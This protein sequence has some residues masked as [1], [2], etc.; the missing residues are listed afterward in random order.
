MPTPTLSLSTPPS[1][2]SL[3]TPPKD[4]RSEFNENSHPIPPRNEVVVGEESQYDV[5]RDG[6]VA[7]LARTL[8]TAI[9]SLS[10]NAGGGSLPPT[11]AALGHQLDHVPLKVDG[12][13]GVELGQDLHHELILKL[14]PL[15]VRLKESSLLALAAAR[16]S[17]NQ[18]SHSAS[19]ASSFLGARLPLSPSS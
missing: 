2:L 6:E 12:E 10:M 14:V 11:R 5:D 3:S 18:V 13:V 19:L 1:T 8:R 17:T 16:T 4:R 9:S 7:R 15:V